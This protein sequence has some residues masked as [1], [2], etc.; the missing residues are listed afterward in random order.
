MFKS[1]R[2]TRI[3]DDLGRR[4]AFGGGGGAL[5]N[6]TMG[7]WTTPP[8]TLERQSCQVFPNFP[9]RFPSFPN[10]PQ[11]SPNFPKLS[12]I[13]PNFPKRESSLENFGANWGSVASFVTPMFGDPLQA[14]VD[15]PLPGP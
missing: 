5:E 3:F 14:L 2:G 15:M 13:F 8:K 7:Y 6:F 1:V 10:F 11:V 4:T 9:K 12:Q